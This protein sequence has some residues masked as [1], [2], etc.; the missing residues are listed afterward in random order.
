[1]A[2]HL[3]RHALRG[4]TLG[5]WSG[6]RK[7]DGQ[8]ESSSQ[9]QYRDED[10]EEEDD[11]PEARLGPFQNFAST[12]HMLQHST[13]DRYGDAFQFAPLPPPPPPPPPAPAA[14]SPYGHHQD[15]L[16]VNGMLTDSNLQSMSMPM[17]EESNL[18]GAAAVHYEMTDSHQNGLSYNIPGYTSWQKPFA[19]SESALLRPFE[20]IAPD[21]LPDSVNGTALLESSVPGS[22]HFTFSNP[23]S[24][25]Y[26]AD[27][28]WLFDGNNPLLTLKTTDDMYSEATG[29]TQSNTEPTAPTEEEEEE[30]DDDAADED[31][32]DGSSRKE[33]QDRQGGEAGALHD[34]A[35][36]AILQR[37][38]EKL[39]FVFFSTSVLYPIFASC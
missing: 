16:Q 20:A 7:R 30:D 28:D 24:G 37:V 9:G 17:R 5:R 35:F 8:S 4:K 39:L 6:K 12:S 19:T 3:E 38:S 33:G 11:S 14:P 15:L 23:Q 29:G 27:Y 21:M 1:M 36:F 26:I 22:G 18:L 34:L 10:D 2:R 32:E 31:D 25:D 13:A